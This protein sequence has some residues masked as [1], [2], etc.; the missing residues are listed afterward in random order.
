[1][2]EIIQRIENIVLDA[3]CSRWEDKFMYSVLFTSKRTPWKIFNY[4]KQVKKLSLKLIFMKTKVM[5]R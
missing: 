2:E 1:M 5:C 4:T 3:N